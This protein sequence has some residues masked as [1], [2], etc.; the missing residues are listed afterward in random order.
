M[1]T[2]PQLPYEIRATAAR[3]FAGRTGLSLADMKDFFTEEIQRRGV[4]PN[5]HSDDPFLGP[6]LNT[7]EFTGAFPRRY[8]ETFE[9][10]R[11]AF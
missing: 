10:L 2:P 4:Q 8:R 7:L 6:I 11:Q 5:L 3:L 9:S 1:S